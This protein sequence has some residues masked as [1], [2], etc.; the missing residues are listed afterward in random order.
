MK[1]IVNRDAGWPIENPKAKLFDEIDV[2]ADEAQ[3]GVE[4]GY[5][6]PA[7]KPAKPVKKAPPALD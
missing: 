7:E 5:L 6:L 4:A 3:K 2:P 1:V